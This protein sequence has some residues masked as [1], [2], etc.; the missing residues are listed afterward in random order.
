M[1]KITTLGQKHWKA[2]LGWNV[3]IILAA[4][5]AISRYPSIYTTKTQ[6]IIPGTGSNLDANL[7]VLGSLKNENPNLSSSQFNALKLQNSFLNSDSVMGQVWEKDPEKTNFPSLRDYKRLINIE[8]DEET[9][10]ISIFIAGSTQ[11]IAQHRANTLLDTYQKRLHKL[12]QSNKA[13]KQQ[14][15]QPEL[16]TAKKKLQKLQLELA[17]FKQSSGLVDAASQTQG[18]VENINQLT[19]IQTEALAQAEYSQKQVIALSGRLNIA[20]SEAISSLSL[21]ENQDYQFVRNKLA[22]LESSLVK[23]RNTYTDEHPNVQM[24]L[25]ERQQ[26]L[27]KQENYIAQASGGNKI[28]LNVKAQGRGSLIQQLVLA[29]SEARGHEQRAQQI[30]IQLNN[31]R[32]ALKSIPSQQAK[33]IELKRQVEIAEGVYKGLVAQVQQTNINAFDAYPNVQVFEPPKVGEKPHNPKLKLIILNALLASVI[34][35]IALVLLLERRNPLLS[36]KDLQRFNFPMVVSIPQIRNSPMRWQFAHD[37]EVELQRLASAISLQPLHNRRL[38]ITSAIEGEGKTT[39][40]LGL[41][42][43]LVE[44]GFRVLVVDGDFRQ[45]ELSR[46]LNSSSLI[47]VNDSPMQIQKNLDFLAMPMVSYQGNLL[48]MLKKGKFERALTT[49]ESTGEYDYVLIDSAPVS[50]TSETLLMTSIVPNTLFVVRPGTSYSNSVNYSLE[51]LA[52]HKAKVV[53]LV[54]NDSQTPTRSY[55]QKPQD[56]LF[57]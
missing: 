8:L 42:T 21:G 31:L 13:T 25:K 4:I 26:L 9:S 1:A 23:K 14:F 28:D 33:L 3:F 54:V 6:L 41:A 36:P 55:Q 16:D 50:L 5:L 53:G 15:S 47:K 19:K 22:E 7:G 20:P 27:R 18:I 35:S 24:L 32:Q 39:V 48:E 52:T 45:Q 2:I 34:G 43:A 49:A 37:T 57:T 30:Q 46:C 12:R 56:V 29:E 40:T 38:L 10:I 17:N 11:E 44:L 51:Q